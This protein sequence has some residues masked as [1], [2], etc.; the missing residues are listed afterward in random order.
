MTQSLNDESRQHI[1]Q[2]AGEGER[3]AA[4]AF[5][6]KASH[7]PR[8]AHPGREVDR[9]PHP[10][11]SRFAVDDHGL[12]AEGRPG[13]RDL[14]RADEGVGP[15]GRAA[16]GEHYHQGAPVR[17]AQPLDL[18]DDR[19]LRIAGQDEIAMDRMRQPAL[20][21]AAGRDHGLADHLAAEHALPARLRAVAA[22]QI[23]L[24]L[25]EIEDG[26]QVDQALGHGCVLDG[27]GL[28][29]VIPGRGAA[30]SPESI[31]PPKLRPDGFRARASRARNDEWGRLAA[32]VSP[33]C[34]AQLISGSKHSLMA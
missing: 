12:Q 13:R 20:D 9:E 10:E 4:K 2:V 26:Q 16:V 11:A 7:A 17:V 14:T 32:L 34:F 28:D 23:H 6:E 8:G 22:E 18:V 5:G 24:E 31:H 30:A 1:E 21:G 33:P 29:V 19:D 15:C 3:R 25:L 27:F